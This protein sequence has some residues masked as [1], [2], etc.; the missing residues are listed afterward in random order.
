MT[1]AKARSRAPQAASSNLDGAPGRQGEKDMLAG[2]PIEAMSL[3]SIGAYMFFE[4]VDSDSAKPL[5]EFL[6][7]SNFIFDDTVPL[8]LFINS[9]GGSV[10][11]GWSIVD[12]M[13]ASRLK[14]QT[15]GIGL[16]ASMA[17]VMFT[18]GTKGSRIMTP[19]SYMMTHQFSDCMEGKFH[20]LVAH[21]E[22]QDDLHDK[23]VKHFTSRTKMTAR[24]VEDVLLGSTDKMLTPKECLKY[25]LCDVIKN[26]WS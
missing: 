8:T 5:C 15:V 3:S 24:Q 25:G 10:Y 7:K 22:H 12:L 20:E 6:I 16:M 19:N 23:F 21:R 13:Y 17:A 26:P 4:E 14:I 9:P 11:D 2:M 1:A 18:A